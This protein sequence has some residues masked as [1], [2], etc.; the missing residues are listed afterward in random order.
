MDRGSRANTTKV[1]QEYLNRLMNELKI[2]KSDDKLPVDEGR[3][4]Q[5]GG[6]ARASLS[7]V[8][9]V[10]IDP[11]A[12]IFVPVD[13]FENVRPT[14]PPPMR[15]NIQQDKKEISPGLFGKENSMSRH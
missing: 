14:P 2:P 15:N 10:N 13:A 1:Q 3:V 9:T 11:T 5:E 4:S 8:T 12:P 7:I 6:Q